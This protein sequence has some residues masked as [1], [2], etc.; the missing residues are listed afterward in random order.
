MVESVVSFL[1]PPLYLLK[2]KV[3]FIFMTD[4]AQFFNTLAKFNA[5]FISTAAR[6][7]SFLADL[8][9][10]LF[11]ANVLV[12]VRMAAHVMRVAGLGFPALH[13]LVKLV[14]FEEEVKVVL[15]GLVFLVSALLLLLF[16]ILLRFLI[17][18]LL[19]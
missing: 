13:R 4:A 17:A 3:L 9:D 14:V 10:V 18:A 1:Q 8:S 7:E 19:I 16:S 2:K 6:L 15:R 5:F 12:F 11:Q